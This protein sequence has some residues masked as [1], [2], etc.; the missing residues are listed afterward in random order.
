[1]MAQVLKILLLLPI[2]GLSHSLAQ[3]E[4]RERPKAIVFDVDRTLGMSFDGGFFK[5]NTH[6]QQLTE[7]SGTALQYVKWMHENKESYFVYPTGALELFTYLIQHTDLKIILAS[8]AQ[9]SLT[10]A[11]VEQLLVANKS[12]GQWMDEQPDRF[13]IAP[14][15][16]FITS[17]MP[18]FDAL[19]AAETPGGLWEEFTTFSKKEAQRIQ[20]LNN[21]AMNSMVDLESM[22]LSEN[23]WPAKFLGKLRKKYQ[24]VAFVDDD[25]KAIHPRDLPEHLFPAWTYRNTPAEGPQRVLLLKI[26]ESGARLLESISKG[27]LRLLDSCSSLL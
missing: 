19:N 6:L 8:A 7:S 17:L 18:E 14:R 13:M 21:P 3:G 24:I 16:E 2:V 15:E 27:D 25:I 22:K 26:D 4:N 9:E 10:R 12:L 5:P 23:G 1:M 20:E 11:K